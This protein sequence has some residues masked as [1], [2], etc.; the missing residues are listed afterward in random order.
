MKYAIKFIRDGNDTFLVISKD[1]K[2]FIIYGQNE[3]KAFIMY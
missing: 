3:K 2:E 1:S